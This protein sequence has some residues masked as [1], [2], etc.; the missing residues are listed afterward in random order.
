MKRFNIF[1]RI[2]SY[3]AFD[4]TNV[5]LFKIGLIYGSSVLWLSKLILIISILV[6]FHLAFLPMHYAWK[7]LDQRNICARIGKRLYSILTFNIYVRIVIQAYITIL[8]SWFGEIYEFNVETG[9]Q[10]ASYWINILICILIF[11]FYGLWILQIKKAHPQLK[12]KRQFYFIEFF[13]G[14]KN[15]TTSRIYPVVF[16]SQK[17]IS[18]FIIIMFARLNLTIKMAILTLI[19]SSSVL[20]LFFAKPFEKVKD[21]I[22]EFLS[23]CIMAFFY[24]ILIFF[25]KEDQSSPILNWIFMGT[26]MVSSAVSS[27]IAITELI[28]LIVKKIKKSW[29]GETKVEH[30]RNNRPT[31]VSHVGPDFANAISREFEAQKK[32]REENKSN[33]TGKNNFKK[34]NRAWFDI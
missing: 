14:L 27:L 18:C 29:C 7:K 20:Y 4:Q 17:I 34:V 9:V 11:I 1:Q 13:S 21:F 30:F 32:Q 25:N 28:I 3:F 16:L 26:L 22:T 10:I 23:Q 15:K 6:L 33:R 24:W 12:P 5:Y 2:Y 8:L 31:V 19:Q